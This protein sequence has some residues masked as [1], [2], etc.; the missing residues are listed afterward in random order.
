MLSMV[1]GGECKGGMG[2]MMEVDGLVGGRAS[3]RL[4]G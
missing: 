3:C 2:K 4:E 1:D